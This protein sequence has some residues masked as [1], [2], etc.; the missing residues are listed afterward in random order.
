MRVGKSFCAPWLVLATAVLL[1]S[2]P[3]LAAGRPPE[4]T[5]ASSSPAFAAANDKRFL[6]I[7][8][9]SSDPLDQLRASIPAEFQDFEVFN[10][11]RTSEG[12]TLYDI[13]LGH[14]A[15]LAD[16]ERAQRTLLRRF[17][18]ASVI[19]VKPTP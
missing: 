11:R 13:C 17:P 18:N 10:A 4:S 15:T 12:K 7:L 8:Q 2:L 16:A 3:A 14:F 1:Q 6:I 19:P 9:S 5:K